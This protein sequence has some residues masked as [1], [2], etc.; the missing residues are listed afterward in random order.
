MKILFFMFLSLDLYTVNRLKVEKLKKRW[1]DER[2]TTQ[3]KL[4][5]LHCYHTFPALGT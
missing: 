1:R 3:R 5:L 4:P 2:V